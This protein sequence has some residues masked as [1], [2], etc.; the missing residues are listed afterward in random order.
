MS[1]QIVSILCSHGCSHSRYLHVFCQCCVCHVVLFLAYLMVRWFVHVVQF[2]D[3]FCQPVRETQDEP[4][5]CLP[6]RHSTDSC[7]IRTIPLPLLYILQQRWTSVARQIVKVIFYFV[8]HWLSNGKAGGIIR[9]KCLPHIR[10]LPAEY[11]TVAAAT[12]PYVSTARC[13]TPSPLP[14]M[15][16]KFPLPPQLLFC[17]HF[18]LIDACHLIATLQLTPAA[19]TSMTA[20]YVPTTATTVVSVAAFCWLLP[21]VWPLLHD[22]P[23]PLPVS[24]PPSPPT[25]LLFTLLL[26][27]DGSLLIVA[28]VLYVE[29]IKYC[30]LKKSQ[31]QYDKSSCRAE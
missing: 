1:Y 24:L 23:P 30:T 2:L 14:P 15:L 4:L 27:V 28:C 13:Y 9:H 17:C 6:M 18:L 10:W 19:T 12:C 7:L 22:L 29:F 26:F 31:P 3:T 5:S 11:V 20:T 25:Q 16:P 21:V 8:S